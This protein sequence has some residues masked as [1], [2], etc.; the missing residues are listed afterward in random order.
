MDNYREQQS[1]IC[2]K[3]EGSVLQEKQL[4][5]LNSMYDFSP[6]QPIT[7][8]VT[9]SVIA[10]WTMFGRYKSVTFA[11]CALIYHVLIN[12][13]PNVCL[14][15]GWT[16]LITNSHNSTDHPFW[17]QCGAFEHQLPVN[18]PDRRMKTY[19]HR[20]SMYPR[21]LSGRLRTSSIT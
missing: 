13:G 21:W 3:G 9:Q 18:H 6:S 11:C 4:C 19:F 1:E 14:C 16:A 2:R 12:S 20:L 5:H 17:R 7:D 10:L 8:I 15:K